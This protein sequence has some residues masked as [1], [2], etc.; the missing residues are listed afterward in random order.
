M[1]AFNRNQEQMRKSLQA[2]FGMFP[3]GQ[4]EEMGKQNMAMFERALKM[5]APY[6]GE[7]KPLPADAAPPPHGAGEDPRLKRLE[8]QIDALDPA[9]RSVRARTRK[10][11]DP[12]MGIAAKICGLASEAAVTAA[13][14]G[15]AGLSRLC[16]LP[17]EPARGAPAMA[18]RLCAAIPQG[19]F[20]VALFVDADD[21]AIAA[22]LDATPIDILQFHG[23][24][25]PDA[26]GGGEGAVWAPSDE[27]G[28]HRR[29]GGCSRRR[30]LRRCR[31][32]AAVRREAAATRRTRCPAATG[33][34]STGG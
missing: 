11:L 28:R 21:D 14:E 30:A 20:R 33:S 27:G 1:V 3:F 34:P 8:A 15:G 12:C 4:F 7:E 31:R 22:V 2:T 23:K 13:V 26:R 24:E 29:A 18:A 9:A 5:L 10:N 25:T 19:I 17:A 16:V 6:G 32:P